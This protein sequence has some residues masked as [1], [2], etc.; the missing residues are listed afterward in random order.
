LPGAALRNE[1]G[2]TA[3]ILSVPVSREGRDAGV[4]TFGL[5]LAGTLQP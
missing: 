5:I 2:Q 3:V 4:L 1:A